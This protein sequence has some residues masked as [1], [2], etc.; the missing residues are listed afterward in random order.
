MRMNVQKIKREY[1]K[2]KFHNIGQM[3]KV[4]AGGG[5]SSTDGGAQQKPHRPK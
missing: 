4:T 5:G 3:I 1:K 2:P